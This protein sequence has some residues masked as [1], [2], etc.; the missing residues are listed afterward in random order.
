M[1]TVPGC[2]VKWVA[3]GHGFTS[4]SGSSGFLCHSECPIATALPA[5][6][7]R[8]DSDPP[9]DKHPGPHSGP[10]SVSG[11]QASILIFIWSPEDGPS[12]A[13]LADT[14]RK[15]RGRDEVCPCRLSQPRRGKGRIQTQDHAFVSLMV[16]SRTH[17]LV[18]CDLC[19]FWQPP[20]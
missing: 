8:N 1:W 9:D 4:P 6:P 7:C 2:Y 5:A 3:Q 17:G 10:P 15:A 19:M 13:H 18:T 20:C 14:D 16:L 12:L 11:H